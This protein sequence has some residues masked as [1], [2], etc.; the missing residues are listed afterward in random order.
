MREKIMIGFVLY[1]M[2]MIIYVALMV[3]MVLK[4]CQQTKCPLKVK[5]QVEKSVITCH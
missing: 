1:S 3:V 2:L 4:T 5:I